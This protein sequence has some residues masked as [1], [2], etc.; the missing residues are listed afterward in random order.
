MGLASL[1]SLALMIAILPLNFIS[2]RL[3]ATNQKK[4]MLMKDER[5]KL[6]NEILN[7][8]KILKLYAWEK[9]FE[10]RLITTIL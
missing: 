5:V 9:S 8:I 4:N 3:V 2:G 6:M 7:G 10:V 1:S